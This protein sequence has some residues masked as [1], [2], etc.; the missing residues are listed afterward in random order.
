MKCCGG[1]SWLRL[2]RT[3][4]NVSHRADLFAILLLNLYRARFWCRYICPLGALLGVAAKNPI[5]RLQ[6]N[7][8]ICNN[9]R[10]CVTDCQGGANPDIAEGWKP[11]ECFYC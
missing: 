10:L 2:S 6:R 4:R 11:S 9:C 8:E 5:V 3:L 7:D 1:T